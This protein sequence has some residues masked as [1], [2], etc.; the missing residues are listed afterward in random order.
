MDENY[1]DRLSAL[2]TAKR[3]NTVRLWSG[4]HGNQGTLCLISV[5]AQEPSLECCAAPS[6]GKRF[7]RHCGRLLVSCGD[8]TNQTS[9]DIYT[10][11]EV[12][13]QGGM[14]NTYLVYHHRIG[15]LAVLKEIRAELAGR[16]KARELFE[17]EAR[18]L[19]SL[20]H[21]GIPRFY[22]FFSSEGSNSL[23]MELIH[24]P[25]LEQVEP[26]SPAQA[27]GWMIEACRVLEYLHQR[28]PPV[29]HR[30]IKPSNLLLRY[31][32]RQIVLIDYGAVKEVSTEP[33]TR[34]ATPGYAAPEQQ[35][36]LPCLQSDFYGIGTTLV[37]LLTHRS[38]EDFYDPRRRQF[39]NLEGG[40]IEAGLAEFIRRTTA[41]DPN[42]RP[43]DCAAMIAGFEPF[44]NAQLG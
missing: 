7:C 5:P 42:E 6:P 12:L 4:S 37:Y 39:G 26:S 3:T 36:G 34:I 32:P 18:V 20:H 28:V 19:Q 17:R 29:I 21:P 43:R 44:A 30:D 9:G 16:A 38:P 40:G 11:I 1:S 35:R 8:I 14:S 10:V 23:V 24:G 41:L 15:K 25:S 33:G 31:S 27:V 13:A 2:S 22:D